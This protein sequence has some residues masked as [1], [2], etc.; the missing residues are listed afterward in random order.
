MAEHKREGALQGVKVVDFTGQLGPYAGKLFVSLGA[1][2]IHLEPPTGDPMRQVSPFLDNQ[3]GP[4]RS[5]SFLYY[6]AGKKSLV[7]DLAQTEG[8]EIF[9]KLCREAD[10]LI[11]SAAPGYLKRL[12]LSYANLSRHNPKLVQVSITPF[13]C[14][15]PYRDFPASDLTASALG[16]FL[17]LAGVDNDKPV[18]VSDDQAYRMAEGYAAV[19]ALLALYHARRTGQGQKVEVSCQEA[20]G[21]ALENAIQYWDLE[22]K[23]RR[24]RGREAG[25][26]TIHPCKDGFIALV[27]IM[28][29][30]KVMWDPFVEWMKSENVEGWQ[31]F[32]DPRWIQPR[33]RSSAEGYERF[34]R[35]FEAYSMQHDKLYLYEKGQSH[36]TAISP[37][38]DGKDLLN[39]PQLQYCGFWQKLKHEALG[40]VE[41]TYPGPACQL[42]NSS[43][44]LGGPAPV[45]G[46]DSA[47]L[48]ARMH[49][50]TAKIKELADKGVIHV[51]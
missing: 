13:G 12:G 46:Q 21:M 3:A 48:L 8:R 15:G 17:Y 6:N 23:I 51:A 35:I 42:G 19:G 9:R 43:W 18:R 45:L 38:S 31:D 41:I 40:G 11:E 7:V 32:E 47:E 2:V 24:G 39:N 26:A 25:T 49:Y 1:E 22:G 44:T 30:N 50:S 33:Y 36:R 27:A 37:V 10:V 20:V 4:E 14:S 16:G 34:C 5:L 28:G 29:E